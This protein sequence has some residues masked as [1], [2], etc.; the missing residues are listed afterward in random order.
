MEGNL[1]CSRVCCG[2]FQ[3]SQRTWIEVLEMSGRLSVP[4]GRLY[5]AEAGFAD[6]T[7]S[8]LLLCSLFAPSD[9]NRHHNKGTIY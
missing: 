2:L 6:K 3:R 9:G 8:L 7:I 4:L 1:A 5:R